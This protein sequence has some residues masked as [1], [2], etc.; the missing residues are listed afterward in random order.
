M[1]TSAKLH[2]HAGPDSYDRAF[3]QT[4]L[5]LQ[6]VTGVPTPAQ[7]A[8]ASE[9]LT[10]FRIRAAQ[11]REMDLAEDSDWLSDSMPEHIAVERAF[12]FVRFDSLMQK[13]ELQAQ[14]LH[15]WLRAQIL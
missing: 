7:Y 2:S 9:K 14:S 4:V 3:L 10:E 5:I 12:L 6:G 15:R 13:T 11:V 8:Q 1:F